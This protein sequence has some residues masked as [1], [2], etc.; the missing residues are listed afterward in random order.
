MDG[1]AGVLDGNAAE[2]PY[3][4]AFSHPNSQ[5]ERGNAYADAQR[6]RADTY[7][8]P[9]ANGKRAKPHAYAFRNPDTNGYRPKPD[10]FR[11]WADA[12][13]DTD[14]NADAFG[15]SVSLRPKPDTYGIRP[16][17]FAVSKRAYPDSDAYR[18]GAD[19][20]SY[21][22]TNTDPDRQRANAHP[23][24]FGADTDAYSQW[25]NTYAY[26]HREWPDADAYAYTYSDPNA[27]S[28]GLPVR[29]HGLRLA[30]IKRLLRHARI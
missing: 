21:A 3:P 10:A 25:P 6:D 12:Q 20:Y 30:C 4:D 27:R 13:P 23:D 17:A 7:A 8:Y 26:A 15:Y 2:R 19:A 9:D 28:S 1:A 22:F 11:D 29:L 18:V 14:A 5:H 16:F 24:S